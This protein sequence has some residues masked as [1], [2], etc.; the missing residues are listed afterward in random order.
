MIEEDNIDLKDELLQNIKDIEMKLI[1]MLNLKEIKID[2][3]ITNL[4]KR[5]NDS[6]EK[7]NITIE[8]YSSQKIDHEKII[9]LEIFKKKVD[10][11]LIAH[12]IRINNNIQRLSQIQSKYDKAIVDN[13]FLPGYIGPSCQFKNLGEYLNYNITEI[14][15][16]RAEKDL[17]K[18][19]TKDYKTKIDSMVKQMIVLNDTSIERCTEYIDN[20][21]KDV[22]SIIDAKIF[23]FTDKINEIK[24]LF[25]NLETQID[26][27][28]NNFKD[29]ILKVLN[30]KD[31]LSNLIDEKNIENNKFINEVHKKVVLNIQDIGI[32]KRKVN[33]IKEL[34]FL[35]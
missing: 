29:E 11:M 31:E 19:D 34:F 35:L 7:T 32:L 15:K 2:D 6:I 21:V 28:I 3:E 14:S 4:N 20:K 10:D 17:I 27:Q 22:E 1:N 12:E 18:K 16:L 9:D 5:I 13:L 26:K 24:I 33:E 8:N 23:D 25:N 30:M